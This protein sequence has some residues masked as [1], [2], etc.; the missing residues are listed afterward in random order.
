MTRTSTGTT[1]VSTPTARGYTSGTGMRIGAGRDHK[2]GYCWTI[3]YKSY[4][5]MSGH[6]NSFATVDEAWASAQAN[7]RVLIT[8]LSK[9]LDT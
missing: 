8:E 1:A 6:P 3:H 7:L 9:G 4:L 2:G 5:L